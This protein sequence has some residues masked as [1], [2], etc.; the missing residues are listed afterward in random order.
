MI[1][2]ID[3]ATG[4]PPKPSRIRAQ[5]IDIAPGTTQP[6]WL[7]V[8]V[9][10]QARPGDYSA[11]V[12][13]SSDQ[14]SKT[15]RILLHVWHFAMP[16]A[17]AV[18]S[19][20]QIYD[21]A[22]RNVATETEV[23]RNRVQVTPVAIDAEGKLAKEYGLKMIG[24]GFWSGASY[25]H[26]TMS[27]PPS[28][29]EIEHVADQQAVDVL[30]DQTA[31]EIGS[32]KNL[33][34]TLVP[35]IKQWGANLHAAGV[36]QLITMAPIAELRRDVDIWAMLAPEYE[37][38]RE[39]VAKALAQGDRAWFYTALS[40]DEYSPKWEVDVPPGDFP[41]VALIDNNL[42]FTGELYWA[43]D[44]FQY[45]KSHD[46]WKDIESNQGGE[47]YAGEGI[48]MYPGDDVGTKGSSHRCA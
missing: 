6:Y 20:F 43:L 15:A 19:D 11:D 45:V 46:P 18:D 24:L 17:P 48:L 26:C 36:L 2:F 35:I 12:T 27:E 23:L 41:I 25:G 34:S 33:R 47:L 22:D 1:P 31:D 8:A 38:A 32:C 28:I 9:S 13:S 37:G 7:D 5:P 39:Q 14:G 44:A 10:K 29:H 42:G 40:Q 16:H 4:K 21:A 30:Y 3:D